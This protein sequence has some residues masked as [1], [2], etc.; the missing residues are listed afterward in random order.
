MTAARGGS[1]AA[2]VLALLGT[3][4]RAS[5][6]QQFP[7]RGPAALSVPHPIPPPV[8]TA[9]TP[10]RDLYQRPTPPIV[11]HP[12][13][14]PPVFYPVP[15]YVYGPFG[16]GPVSY[17]PHEYSA[18]A[19]PSAAAIPAIARGGLRLESSPGSAQVFVDGL[20]VGLADDFGLSGRALDLDEGRH[21]VELRATG[22]ATLTFDVRIPANQTTR[23]R[24]DLEKLSPPSAVSVAPIPPATP[25]TMYIIPNC[26]AGD[27]PPSR[28]LPPG[29]DVAKM[30]VHK[31]QGVALGSISTFIPKPKN[32]CRPSSEKK[33][34]PTRVYQ[35]DFLTP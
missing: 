25:K 17:D 16:Y 10:P 14:R 24:G 31:A 26:Y 32:R 4:P 28:A 23:Y 3:V 15:V 13:V 27:R 34:C 22:Y 7:L 8:S 12:I 1:I 11:T 33:L 9:A 5:A 19:P 2:L 18:E 29:C 6:A 21:R 20:F 30:I 35:I